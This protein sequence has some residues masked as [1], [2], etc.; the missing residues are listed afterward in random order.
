MS[1][2]MVKLKIP[3]HPES[4]ANH[5]RKKQL[6]RRRFTDEEASRIMAGSTRTVK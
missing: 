3:F 6:R 1:R 5:F 4:R 2:T